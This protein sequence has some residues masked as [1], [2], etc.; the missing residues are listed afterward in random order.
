MLL[1][2]S[3]PK[4]GNLASRDAKLDLFRG[5]ICCHLL[6][7]GLHPRHVMAT[8]IT[9]RHERRKKPV[10]PTIRRKNSIV[11]QVV[12]F[13]SSVRSHAVCFRRFEDY[14]ASRQEGMCAGPGRQGTIDAQTFLQLNLIARLF[15]W[16]ACS[17]SFS[18]R[19]AGS[20]KRG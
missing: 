7:P 1:S 9:S 3:W 20:R 12:D 8:V 4:S 5:G 17:A 6:G 10:G 11:H 14:A 15:L 2:Q 16:I 19:P 13:Q 18:H